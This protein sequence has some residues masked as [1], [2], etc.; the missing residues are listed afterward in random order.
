MIRLALIFCILISSHSVA[1]WDD[2]IPPNQVQIY[3]P[4]NYDPNIP[5][6]V[7]IFL[8]GYNPFTTGW[9]DWLIALN[10]DA[11]ER[12]YIFANP[13]GSQDSVGEYYWNATDACCDM[14]DS[15]NDHV[16]YLL[17]LVDSIKANYNIDGQSIHVVGYSNGGF[18]AHRLACDAPNVFASFISIA[19]AMWQDESN[20]Q[21]SE[22]AHVLEIHGNWDAVIFWLGGYLGLDLVEY[23]SSVTTMEFWAQHNG[24]STNPSDAGSFDFDW[25]IWFD[26]TTRWVYENCEDPSA[27]SAELWEINT[28][29]HFP[30]MTNEG[31]DHL[32]SYM[33]THLNQEHL[34][35]ADLNDDQTVN[36][37]DL[38]FVIKAWGTSDQSADITNDGTVDVN[39][40]LQ[41]VSAWGDC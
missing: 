27:G 18:M 34:C 7:I 28:G 1:Q 40:L 23:P 38:L 32:F 20:C 35:I 11:Y 19:G 14:F 30:V 6:P 39:D 29:S 16:G 31:I 3:L 21:P 37:S 8:H 13:T 26:E 5:T 25:W 4:S 36:V 15:N 33:E 12:G 17:A 9:S 41:I 24:C 10:D 22:Q 2:Q